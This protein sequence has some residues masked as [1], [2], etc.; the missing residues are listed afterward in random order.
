MPEG[1][2][3]LLLSCVP[4]AASCGLVDAGLPCLESEGVD[5]LDVDLADD[6]LTTW[7][8]SEGVGVGVLD[9]E[10]LTLNDALSIISN[11]S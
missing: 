3:V 6:G 8:G 1:V 2:L 4:E 5:V 9:V 7:L 11:T 10:L